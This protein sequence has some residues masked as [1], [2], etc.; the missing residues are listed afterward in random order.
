MLRTTWPISTNPSEN[1][2]RPF[3]IG[4]R[5][6]R[7]CDTV[8]GTNANASLYSLVKNLQGQ[9]HRSVPV[10]QYLV[11]LFKALPH[12][13]IADDYEPLLPWRLRSSDV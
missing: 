11:A 4:R 10:F 1:A 13:R 2:I 3:L 7:F 5:N 12:A 6:F 8:A 9:R